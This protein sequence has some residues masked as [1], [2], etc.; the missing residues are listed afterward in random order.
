MT[1]FGGILPNRLTKIDDLTRAD[2]S[3]L[4]A[5][6]DC[7]FIGEYTARKGF[8]FSDTNG[9]ISN[10]KKPMNRRGRSEWRYKAKAIADA[11]AAFRESIQPAWLD[12]ATLVPMPPSKA[13]NHVDYDDRMT[14]VVRAIRTQPPVDCREL[15]IQATSTEAAHLQQDRPRPADIEALYQID[16]GLAVPGP[17]VI[18]VFDDVLTT[19]A[20]FKGAKA[21]LQRHFPGITIIGLFVARR[22]PEAIDWDDF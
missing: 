21:V 8:S 7:Y 14:Q 17:T 20:H 19:G 5:E 11:A 15:L 9:L 2:H 12:T 18:G 6:D 22:V 10:L 13:R 1:T 3:Y 16:P 4:N